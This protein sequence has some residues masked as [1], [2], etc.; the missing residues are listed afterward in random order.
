MFKT[1]ANVLGTRLEHGS[2]IDTRAL[3]NGNTL[4]GLVE[5][6]SIR[7][8]TTFDALLPA[9]WIRGDVVTRTAA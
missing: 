6:E 1:G 8:I 9:L 3:A 2:F 5:N 7:A 4:A